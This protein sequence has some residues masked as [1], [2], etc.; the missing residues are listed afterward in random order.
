METCCTSFRVFKSRNPPLWEILSQVWN[1]RCTSTCSLPGRY[2]K[3][4]LNSKNIRRIDEVRVQ[5]SVGIVV[6]TYNISYI[7]GTY[8]S[9]RRLDTCCHRG[10]QRGRRLG[11]VNRWTNTLNINVPLVF[12]KQWGRVPL[13]DG[14]LACSA[15]GIS[16][17][18]KSDNRTKVK[19]HGRF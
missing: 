16:T 17:W 10:E 3:Q 7:P 5:R 14:S 19:H 18:N 15:L 11:R 1:R 4:I 9:V 8:V 2:V 13:M 12:P 6:R